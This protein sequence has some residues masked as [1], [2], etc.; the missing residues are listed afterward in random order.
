MI[1]RRVTYAPAW[2]ERRTV[3]VLAVRRESRGMQ[4]YSVRL[5]E[6]DTEPFTVRAEFLQDTSNEERNA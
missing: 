5:L 1:G 4:L 6:G 2:Q 3:E